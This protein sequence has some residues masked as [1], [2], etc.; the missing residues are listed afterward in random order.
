VTS[1]GAPG[2]A[3]TIA[4]AAISDLLAAANPCAKL[5]RGDEILNKLGTGAD[6]VKAAIGMVAAEQNFNP[7]ETPIP[8]I[9]A[10]KSL[11]KH[12]VLRGITPL[13]DPAVKGSAKANALSKQTQANPLDATGKSVADLLVENGFSNF[14]AEDLSGKTFDPTKGAPAA[15]ASA[16]QPDKLSSCNPPPIGAGSSKLMASVGLDHPLANHLI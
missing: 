2:E 1:G 15:A 5:Q 12:Q 13:I 7:F 6:S 16:A 4:G 10:D 8:F 9:C 14:T 3:A 11:P